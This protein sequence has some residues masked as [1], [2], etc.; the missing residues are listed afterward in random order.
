MRQFTVVTGLSGSGKTQVV[1]FLEDAGFFCIDNMPPMLI[2]Q[3]A[4]MFFSMNGKYEKIAFV[5]DIRVGELINELLDNIKSLRESGYPCKLLFLDASDETLVKRYKETR[6]V[7]PLSGNQGLLESIRQERKM[8]E[9]L[10]SEA[11]EVLDTTDLSLHDLSKE[12]KRIYLEQEREQMGIDVISFG[13]KYGIPLDSDLVFDVRCFPNPF[14][15][16][17]LK[18]KTGMQQEVRDYVMSF[19]ESQ[20]FLKKLEDMMLFLVPLYTEEGKTSLSIAIGCT[21]GKHRSVT[22][23]KLLSDTLSE[24]GYRVNLI[25]RDIER[26]K[27]K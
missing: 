13:F 19:A 15:I 3:F 8:L 6:R 16:P 4:N 21:G 17:E 25:N 18:H 27:R 23:A 10:Y 5:V 20:A 11:D 22:M 7:H 2:P 12:L 1:R 14:Y 24:K 9:Q 26:G